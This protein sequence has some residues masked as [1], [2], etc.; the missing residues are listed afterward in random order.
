MRPI[1]VFTAAVLLAVVATLLVPD[2]EAGRT[3]R[4]VGEPAAQLAQARPASRP[5]QQPMG[6]DPGRV[7]ASVAASVAGISDVTVLRSRLSALAPIAAERAKVEEWLL[8]DADLSDLGRV[9]GLLGAAF[10]DWYRVLMPRLLGGRAGPEARQILLTIAIV[11]PIPEAVEALERILVHAT[12]VQEPSPSEAG[13]IEQAV[14]ALAA[15]DEVSAERALCRAGLAEDRSVAVRSIVAAALTRVREPATVDALLALWQEGR[16]SVGDVVGSGR[17]KLPHEDAAEAARAAVV[18][19]QA[20]YAAL[21]G[22][23]CAT[24]LSGLDERLMERYQGAADPRERGRVVHA[25]GSGLPHFAASPVLRRALADPDLGIRISAALAL[26]QND[27]P[28]AAPALLQALGAATTRA[29]RRA[30]LVALSG[31]APGDR[32]CRDLGIGWI[33]KLGD[34]LESLLVCT[35]VAAYGDLPEE[36]VLRLRTAA[37]AAVA[38][39]SRETSVVACR[40]CARR[41]DAG[42]RSF[43]ELAL[44]AARAAWAGDRRVVGPAVVATL[45]RLLP[46]QAASEMLLGDVLGDETAHRVH[47]TALRALAKVIDEPRV[48]ECVVEVALRATEWGT[49]QA[50]KQLLE[51]LPHDHPARRRLV[52]NQARLSAAA[53]ECLASLLSG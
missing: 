37:D 6:A 7:N 8:A 47:P 10:P 27:V 3:L 48:A 2:R 21:A 19:T 52:S 43:D 1:L 32:A 53:R 13:A 15:I 11:H 26:A 23:A 24:E 9:V 31:T 18:P 12:G 38:S 35:H 44:A 39:R 49:L 42:D 16:R 33:T 34:P 20:A 51:R 40:L 29:E 17:T 25:A 36:V 45:E 5:P 22:L 41:L 50:I 14:M 30:I 4:E 46:T 28:D